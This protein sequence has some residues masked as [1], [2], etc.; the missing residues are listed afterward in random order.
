MVCSEGVL[1]SSTLLRTVWKIRE[2]LLEAQKPNTALWVNRNACTKQSLLFF[3]VWLTNV[4]T[5]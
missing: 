4:V 1:H 2:I 3:V 5:V